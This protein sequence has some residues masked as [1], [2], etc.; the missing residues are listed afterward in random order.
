MN[1]LVDCE[2]MKYPFTGLYYYCLHLGNA[3]LE[4]AK[5]ANE[6]LTFFLPEERQGIFG[7]HAAYLKQ[8]FLHKVFMPSVHEFQVW[9]ATHQSTDY[10]PY[11]KKISVL[12]TVHDINFMHDENKKAAKKTKYLDDLKRKIDRANHIVA[13]S[14]FTLNDLGSYI[15]LT[16]KTCSVV[17]N[18]CN[19]NERLLHVPAPAMAPAGSFLFTIGT[20]AEKKNFHVLPPLLAGNNY[21]LVIAGVTND[22]NYRNKI[23][24]EAEKWKVADRIVFTGAIPEADKQWYFQHCTAFVLPSLAEGFG[25]PVLEAMFY[26]KP[27][28]LSKKGSLPEIGGEAA[29]Y[30]DDFL[31]ENMRLTLR[32]GLERYENE[33]ALQEK[34]YQHAV[35]F[36]WKYA[37]RDYL[38]VYRQLTKAE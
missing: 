37:A 5:P 38:A 16:G 26:R 13:V 33:I 7:I 19:F 22:K 10:Y 2:R 29:Y 3:L 28:F 34:I 6:N 8:H 27:V 14:R 35:S 32:K 15:D 24:S 9:H 25:L 18:G 31:P 21:R 30:F 23:L 20:I 17:Y 4:E 12:L 11:N 1:I 36:D